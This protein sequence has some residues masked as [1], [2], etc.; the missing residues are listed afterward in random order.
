MPLPENFFE[1]EKKKRELQDP[2]YTY[3][4]DDQRSLYDALGE[5]LWSFGEHFISGGTMGL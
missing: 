2:S 3:N 1:E 4:V 5:G